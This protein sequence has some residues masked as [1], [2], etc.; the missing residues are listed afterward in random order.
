VAINLSRGHTRIQCG[1]GGLDQ[2]LSP[3]LVARNL[4]LMAL[5]VAA[6]C[7]ATERTPVWLDYGAVALTTLALYGL[8]ALANTLLRNHAQLTDLRNAP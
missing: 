1:C 8:Y 7:P 3:A 2:P 5:A 4:A 6:A